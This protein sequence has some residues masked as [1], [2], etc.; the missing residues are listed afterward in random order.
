[1]TV[2]FA[3]AAPLGIGHGPGQGTRELLHGLKPRLQGHCC[4]FRDTEGFLFSLFFF[5]P[6]GVWVFLCSSFPSSSGAAA[7]SATAPVR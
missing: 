6:S 1:M 2:A 5:V 7:Y 3:I 4:H